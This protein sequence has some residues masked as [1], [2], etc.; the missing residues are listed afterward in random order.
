MVRLPASRTGRLYPQEM[1]LVLI[2]T[3]GWVDPRA[4]VRSEGNMSLKNPVTPPAIDRG[5]VRLVSQRLKNYAKFMNIKYVLI[6]ATTFVWN[7]PHSKRNSARYDHKYIYNSS[8]KVPFIFS[9]F[10]EAG[11]FQTDFGK[12]TQISDLIKISPVGAALF[13][14]ERGMDA[15]DRRTDMTKLSVAFFQICERV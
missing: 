4:M 12:N 10:N 5:T 14:A 3:R 8:F 13:H 6:F 11:I 9:D 2:F 1:F 15:T 7:I